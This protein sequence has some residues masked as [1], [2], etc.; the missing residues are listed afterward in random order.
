MSYERNRVVQWGTAFV[1]RVNKYFFV[2]CYYDKSFVYNVFFYHSNNSFGP[3]KS[4]I[5]D[6]D[7]ATH[8]RNTPSA[9]LG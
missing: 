2:V 7:A 5:V 8:F 4:R 1:F 9:A 6:E 3:T